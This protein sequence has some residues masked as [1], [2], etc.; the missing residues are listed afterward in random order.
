MAISTPSSNVESYSS[1]S[2][3]VSIQTYPIFQTSV[4]QPNGTIELCTGSGSQLM[5]WFQE[6][7][8][9]E[10]A[11]EEYRLFKTIKRVMKDEDCL[12]LFTTNRAETTTA[13]LSILSRYESA[14]FE[15]AL[16]YLSRKDGITCCIVDAL[17]RNWTFFP[18]PYGQTV[19]L[20]LSKLL[21]DN[22]RKFIIYDE[23]TD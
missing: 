18:Q 23:I 4:H 8:D 13:F 21:L 10:D 16:R 14:A 12:A 20:Q 6:I 1:S 9:Y 22:M 15:D 7:L 11:G 19:N 17:K 3:G 2:F 5:T